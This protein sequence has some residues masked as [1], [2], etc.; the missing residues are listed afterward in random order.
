MELSD[1]YYRTLGFY[2]PSLFHIHLDGIG[3]IK[4]MSSWEEEQKST[5][6]HEYVHFLQDVTTVQGLN[7]MYRL[8][9]FVRYVTNC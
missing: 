3:R 6:L 7:N 5:F 9:E 4:D 2:S 8:G 1:K